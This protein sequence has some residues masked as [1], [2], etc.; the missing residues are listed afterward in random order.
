[1]AGPAWAKDWQSWK[2]WENG[3]C[4]CLEP[5]GHNVS[6]SSRVKSRMDEKVVEEFGLNY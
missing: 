3:G 1:M 2:R 6:I 5:T 4:L